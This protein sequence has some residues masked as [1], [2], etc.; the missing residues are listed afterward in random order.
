LTLEAE[1]RIDA[2]LSSNDGFELAERDLAIRG[3]G[4]LLGP[5]QHGQIA[6]ILTADPRLVL[7]ARSCAE[8]LLGLPASKRDPVL[9]SV[10]KDLER[11]QGALE[12]G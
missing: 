12:A 3:P 8:R 11:Y 6:G 5:R 1:Q 10:L 4:E 7:T 2:M 9:R